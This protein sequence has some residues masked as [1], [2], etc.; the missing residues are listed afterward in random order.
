MNLDP[1]LPAHGLEVALK[2]LKYSLGAG[3]NVREH[4]QFDIVRKLRT[5]YA[6]LHG[7]L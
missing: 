4:L 2:V 1:N 5:S 6:H 3:L 7:N